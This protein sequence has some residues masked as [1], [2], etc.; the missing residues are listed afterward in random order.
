MR[1]FF[2]LSAKAY[3][4]KSLLIVALI[5]I[6]ISVISGFALGLISWIPLVGKIFSIV[7]Q[8]IDFYCL[9][10]IVVAAIICFKI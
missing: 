10:G 5:Y 7:S 8:L 3:D 1:A 4:I 2:P 6:A 9:S